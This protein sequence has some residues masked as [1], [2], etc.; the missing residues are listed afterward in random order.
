M[1]VAYHLVYLANN[2]RYRYGERLWNDDNTAKYFM[3]SFEMEHMDLITEYNHKGGLYTMEEYNRS[4]GISEDDLIVYYPDESFNISL[5]LL[6]QSGWTINIDEPHLEYH[7]KDRITKGA[8]YLFV[9][10]LIVISKPELQ[11]FLHHKV[12]Q[13]DHILIY[14]LQ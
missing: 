9:G 7:I 10:D 14:Q 4:L 6:N 13:H 5:F 2:A 8:K 11:V 1:L 3:S 12:G